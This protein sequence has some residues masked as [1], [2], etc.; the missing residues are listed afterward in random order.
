M[1]VFVGAVS[2]L[3]WLSGCPK[4]EAPPDP[5]AQADGLYLVGTAA[6]LKG[7]FK[8]AHEAFA[9]VKTLNPSDKR[10]PAAEGEVFLA[11]VKL[12]DAV[13]SFEEAARLDPKR[14]TTWSRLGFIYALEGK[15][16]VAKEALTKALEL[17]PR[18]FNA[19]EAMGELDLKEGHLD[20]AVRHF[21]A[22]S[23]AAP[24]AARAPLVIRA[25][26]ELTRQGRGAQSL[27]ILEDSAKAGIQG[28]ELMNELGDRLVEA[29]RLPEA[30]EAYSDA[31]RGNPKDPA[32]WELVGELQMKL[33]NPDQAQ[34]AFRQSLKIKDR[35]VVHASLARLC[36]ARKDVACLKQELDLALEKASG[37]EPRELIDI[38]DLLAS[39]GRKEDALKLLKA[40]AEEE[41]Q[42]GDGALQLKLV[43]LAKEV[44]D[45][46]T[47]KSACLRVLASDAGTTKCP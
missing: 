32:L 28:P 13:K 8:A 33:H 38:A 47:V 41:A 42:H 30:V 2:C 21:L 6:Y 5:K 45:K 7:D 12:D 22:A 17:N 29:N 40:L 46:A 3:L 31:A 44:G 39:L 16:V 14:A 27:Q 34:T 19:L 23:Q 20:E 24:D 36:Q 10:L 35:G 9:Q 11:E 25:V 37:E 43:K 1:R 4:D 18:D 15:A 26:E